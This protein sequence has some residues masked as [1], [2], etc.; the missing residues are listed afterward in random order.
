MHPFIYILLVASLVEFGVYYP[1]KRY[2]RTLYSAVLFLLFFAIAAIL[3]HE[4]VTGLCC[5][6]T[7]IIE[8]SNNYYINR[9]EKL[10]FE[11]WV[12]IML[13]GYMMS[14]AEVLAGLGAFLDYFW[15]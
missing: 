4:I 6:I 14:F 7:G 2:K 13:P 10:R 5:I 11:P 8:F 12:R 3:N 9:I 15:S 1:Q